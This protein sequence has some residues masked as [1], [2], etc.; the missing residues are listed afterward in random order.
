MTLYERIKETRTRKGMSQTDLA[1][2]AGYTDRSSIAKIEAGAVDLTQSKVVAIANALNVTPSYLL[3]WTDNAQEDIS[4][5]KA[6][7]IEKIK[8]MDDETIA[9]L[10]QI[11][12]TIISKR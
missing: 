7:L 6:E 5:K 9:A 11:A 12:D 1:K 2:L 10:N 4:P 3:G 8:K